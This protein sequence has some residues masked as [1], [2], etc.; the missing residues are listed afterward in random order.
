MYQADRFVEYA[1]K[2]IKQQIPQAS[3]DEI[4]DLR[5]RD[6]D[7]HAEMVRREG[8]AKFRR[9]EAL[10]HEEEMSYPRLDIFRLRAEEALRRLQNSRI[11]LTDR[12]AKLDRMQ[13]LQAL[14]KEKP[15]RSQGEDHE[16]LARLAELSEEVAS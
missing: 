7:Q 5:R 6:R 11:R 4:R 1:A 2:H 3:M 12:Q 15:D 13:Q 16:T 9:A 8:E 14:L 10:S